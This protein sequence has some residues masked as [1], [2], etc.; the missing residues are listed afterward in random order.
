M[1]YVIDNTVTEARFIPIKVAKS[2]YPYLAFLIIIDT[3]K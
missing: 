3:A 2:L 1:I